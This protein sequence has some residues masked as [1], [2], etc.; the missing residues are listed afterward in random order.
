MTKIQDL[1]KQIE[2][3]IEKLERNQGS[4]DESVKIFEQAMKDIKKA[5]D[6]LVKMEAKVAEISQQ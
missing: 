6:V 1:F 3:S 4:I 5:K 2:Q